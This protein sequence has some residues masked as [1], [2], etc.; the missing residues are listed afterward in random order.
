MM[1]TIAVIIFYVYCRQVYCARKWSRVRG[2]MKSSGGGHL[3][4]VFVTTRSIRDLRHLARR[5]LSLTDTAVAFQWGYYQELD[6][7]WRQYDLSSVK[8]VNDKD[9]YQSSNQGEERGREGIELIQLLVMFGEKLPPIGL[10]LAAKRI[11]AVGKVSDRCTIDL[12]KLTTEIVMKKT[13]IC[14]CFSPEFY[15]TA[16]HRAT[17]TSK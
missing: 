14:A 10:S 1:T 11:T 2:N 12:L 13:T 7:K 9:V 6:R 15:L 3:T 4:M 5:G 8:N 16:P 17:A